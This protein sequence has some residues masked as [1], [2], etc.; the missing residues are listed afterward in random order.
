MYC[1]ST[2][3]IFTEQQ[4]KDF[5]LLTGDDG[6]V[7]AI[8]NVVQG[9]LIMSCLPKFINEAFVNNNIQKVHFKSVSAILEAKFRNKLLANKTVIAEFKFHDSASSVLKVDWKIYDNS[10]EYCAGKWVIYKSNI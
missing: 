3:V 7:H 6:P 9:G 5:G 8:D 1:I 10:V 2:Q 4:I